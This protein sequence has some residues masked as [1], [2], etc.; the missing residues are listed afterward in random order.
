MLKILIILLAALLAGC[1][2]TPEKLG[3]KLGEKPGIVENTNTY[4]PEQAVEVSLIVSSGQTVGERIKVP[5][6]FERIAVEADSFGEYLRNLPLKPHGSEVKYYNGGT[7]SNKVYEAVLDIDVGERDLQQCAD[8]VMRLRAEYL[9]SEDLFDRIHF[10]FINGFNADY[11]KWRQGYRIKVDGNEAYWVRQGTGTSGNYSDFRKYLDIVF[12]YAGTLSLSKEM[13]KVHLE[14]MQIGDVFIKGA[15]P[16]HCVIVIDMAEN[17]TTN[18]KIFLLAQSY[19]PAQD[20]HVLKNLANDKGNPWYS[21]DFGDRL[22]TPEW[23]F[24]K[25]Q[26][27]RFAD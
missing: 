18:E 22:D 25:D 23:E 26:L 1:S 5:E 9:Y 21:T 20:I 12:A 4:Q 19:M 8:A 17:K 2:A 24:T 14:D 27:M 15:S 7:K 6:G 11:K 13:Q 3:E 10:K 16:G